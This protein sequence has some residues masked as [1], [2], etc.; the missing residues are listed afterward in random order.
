MRFGLKHLWFAV[1][2]LATLELSLAWGLSYELV[3]GF[4]DALRA[5]PND[6]RIWARVTLVSSPL[7]L[8]ILACMLRRGDLGIWL[9]GRWSARVSVVTGFA[10]SLVVL[11]ISALNFSLLST[12]GY[13]LASMS[14]QDVVVALFHEYGFWVFGAVVVIAAPLTEELLFREIGLRALSRYLGFGFANLLQATVFA[15]MHQDPLRF[16]PL[17]ALG[18]L[19]GWLRRRS[20]SLLAPTMLHAANNAIAVAA[21]TAMP[22]T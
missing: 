16:A 15:S 11:S 22:L 7:G 14:S 2:A 1:G 9:E 19:G 4:F 6:P 8:V 13:S 17:F 12:L 5:P 20:G 21:I 18:L 3:A 10:S